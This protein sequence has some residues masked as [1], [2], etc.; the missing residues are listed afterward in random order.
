MPSEKP[1]AANR[2]STRFHVKFPIV[3]GSHIISDIAAWAANLAN[4]EPETKYRR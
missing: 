2:L 4:C 3:I 1:P